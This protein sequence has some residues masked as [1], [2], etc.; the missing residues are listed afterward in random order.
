[1]EATWNPVEEEYDEY[2]LAGDIGGS[3]TNLAVVG[4]RGEVYEIA[5][6]FRFDSPAVEDFSEVIGA[7][8][9]E[10]SKHAPAM[11]PASACIC[12]AGPI[13]GN[14]CKPTNLSWTVDGPALEN[15]FSLPFT[16][17]N[18]FQAIC[19]G[20]PLLTGKEKIVPVPHTDG[21]I[22]EPTGDSRAIA[23]AGTGLGVGFLTKTAGRFESF[24]SEGGHTGF[25]PFDSD[26]EGLYR[27]IA[28]RYD[29]EPGT[30]LFLSGRGMANIFN[31]F[32]D[33]KKVPLEGALLEINAVEDADKP[34][35]ITR[36]TPT[37]PG[38]REIMKLFIKIYGHFA[39]RVSLFFLPRAGMYIAGGIVVRHAWL[40]LEDNN[41]ISEYEKSYNALM[42]R[43]LKSIPVYI[44][45]DYSVSLLGAAHA[46]VLTGKAGSSPS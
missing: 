25:A 31:Y 19:Y 8:L 18:D 17:M 3:N 26:S 24:P 35:L 1:M 29:T 16:V 40:F 44:V 6:K 23:G 33:V 41:F 9:D 21:T 46:A 4:R 13:S 36:Y 32:R 27:Y 22:P 10:I 14:T 28:K 12:A 5:A 2:L 15:R 37:D 30:E 20:V 39:A 34:P 43:V 45:N 7:A 11:V 42:K 38:C